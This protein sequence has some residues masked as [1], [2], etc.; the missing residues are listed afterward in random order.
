MFKVMNGKN[1]KQILL[2][3][4][5]IS[6]RLDQKAKSFTDKQKKRIQ[7]YQA[8]FT[9]KAKG[10]SLGRKQERD[11]QKPKTIKKMVI[12]TFISISTLNVNRLNV[13]TDTDWLNGYKNKICMYVVYKRLQT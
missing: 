13:P 1:L 8:S 11:P 3:S 6:F 10:N 4:A 12:G 5:K 7:H 2:Y 9:T